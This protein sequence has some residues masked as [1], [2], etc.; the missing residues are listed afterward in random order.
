[1][2]RYSGIETAKH[3]AI[4]MVEWLRGSGRRTNQPGSTTNQTPT[5]GISLS[6]R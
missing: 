3:T 5:A 2:T 4:A 6:L 1:M